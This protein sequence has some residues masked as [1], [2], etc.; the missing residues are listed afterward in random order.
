MYLNFVIS[1]YSCFREHHF[2]AF[3]SV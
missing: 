3:S 2:Q 1:G